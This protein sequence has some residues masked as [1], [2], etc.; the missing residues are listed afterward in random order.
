MLKIH[1]FA[2]LKLKNDVI[3]PILTIFKPKIFWNFIFGYEFSKLY[4]KNSFFDAKN[5]V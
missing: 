1:F 2:F 3:N 5:N 4:A